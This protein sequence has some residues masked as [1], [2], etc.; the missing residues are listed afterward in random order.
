MTDLQPV[1]AALAGLAGVFALIALHVPIGVA[2]AVAGAIGVAWMIGTEPALALFSIE[3]ASALRNQG[4][5]VIP[6]FLL[7]GELAG[8]GG[9]ADDVFDLARAI[10]GRRRGG[11]AMATIAGAAGFGAVCGSSLATTATMSRMAYKPMRRAGYAAELAAGSV[12]AGGTLGILIPPSVLL[13]L[14]GLL[15]EE[16]V[17]ALFAAAFVPGLIAIALY[18]LAIVV[19]VSRRPE[20]APSEPDLTAA[21]RR[22]L[23]LGSWRAW[24]L[25]GG[26]SVGLYSGVFTV[27][28]AASVGVTLALGLSLGRGLLSRR[29]FVDALLTT[30]GTTSMIYVILIGASIFGYFLSLTGAAEQIVAAIGDSGWPPFAII[31]CLML[32]YIVLGSV[33]DTVAAMVITLPFVL[34]LVLDLGYSP[35]WW[36]VMMVMLMEIGMITPPIGLNV[37]VLH[38]SVP[39]LRLGQIY[40]GVAPFLIA[41]IARVVL[42]AAL[43]ALA[44]TLPRWLGF[45]G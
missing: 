7:M 16:Y 29:D 33:F 10:V 23:A 15:T 40:R 34:P 1:I 43:P 45:I 37:F 31:I 14:Y 30:A 9:L 18:L 39:E 24:V 4:L 32:L 13:I 44:L 36:G 8:R 2:M 6:L 22:R 21:E 12:A 5:A 25:A 20:Q 41:D 27:L 26:V 38:G 35:I 28:E 3:T 11:L 19:G 17:V 42:I